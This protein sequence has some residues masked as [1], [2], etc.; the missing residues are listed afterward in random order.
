M[1]FIDFNEKLS[2]KDFKYIEEYGWVTLGNVVASATE[3]QL[4]DELT[5]LKAI[6]YSLQ[7]QLVDA[8]IFNKSSVKFD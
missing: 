4:L 8:S 2:S 3:S 6:N 7:R 1:S 5:R